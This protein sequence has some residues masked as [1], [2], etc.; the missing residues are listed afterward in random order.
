MHSGGSRP[1]WME[2]NTIG[3]RGMAATVIISTKSRRLKVSVIVPCAAQHVLRLPE[4]MEAMRRQ[5]RLPDEVVI[6][7]SGCALGAIPRLDAGTDLK[8]VHNAER[9]TAG[10]NRNRAVVSA[11]GDVVVFQDAD[12]LPHLQR[13]E[14]IVALFERY[15]IDHLM[16]FFYYLKEEPSR[17][18]IEQAAACSTYRTDFM[19]AVPYRTGLVKCVTNG[20]VAVMREIAKVVQWPDR[21]RK[22]EDVDF[23]SAVYA[24]TKRTAVT[25]LPLIT[26][27]RNFSSFRASK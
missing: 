15:E 16:H 1:W 4:L 21:S 26:Y 2:T 20:N 13:V 24:R 12:D 18:S 11:R 25:E 9:I 22:G 17:F 5:T 14:I 8:I 7:V 23:N 10:G 27:R 19:K 6:A 3:V